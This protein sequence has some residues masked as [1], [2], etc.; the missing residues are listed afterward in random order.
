[1]NRTARLDH[2]PMAGAVAITMASSVS[3]PVH[4]MTGEVP[5]L[6]RAEGVVRPEDADVALMVIRLKRMMPT[7]R[8]AIACGASK[9]SVVRWL[10][11]E[12][13]PT[14]EQMSELSAIYLAR[15][16]AVPGRGQ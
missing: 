2:D 6:A 9:A 7:S 8:I 12:K 13:R 16:G 5:H 15:I 4:L 14:D 3:N 10:A 1:M 11:N